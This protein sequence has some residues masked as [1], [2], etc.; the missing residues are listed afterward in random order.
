MPGKWA[1]PMPAVAR[2]LN[3]RR[4]PELGDHPAAGQPSGVAHWLVESVAYGP[5]QQGVQPVPQ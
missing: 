5:L 1:K 3:E 4:P 2:R